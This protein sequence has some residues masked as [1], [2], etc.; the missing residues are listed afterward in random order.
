MIGLSS[1]KKA[2]LPRNE[3]SR[4]SSKGTPLFAPQK[5]GRPEAV[6]VCSDS[7]IVGRGF[8]RDIKLS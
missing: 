6:H 3:V 8:S 2:C 5:V 1:A 7:G 4:G